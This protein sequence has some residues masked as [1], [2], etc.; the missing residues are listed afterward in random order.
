MLSFALQFIKLGDVDHADL[1]RIIQQL[2]P[3]APEFSMLLESQLQNANV[4]DPRGW[5]WD[6][7]IITL[8]LHLWAKYEI[9]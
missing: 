4:K 8:C 6:K 2:L 5:K 9:I 3:Q 1:V 7:R